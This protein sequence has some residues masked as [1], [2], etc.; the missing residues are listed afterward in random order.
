MRMTDSKY[1]TGYGHS[2]KKRRDGFE[3]INRMES[4]IRNAPRAYVFCFQGEFRWLPDM[5]SNHDSASPCRI[6]KLLIL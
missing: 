6:N 3:P 1:G 2:R 5:D 4:M